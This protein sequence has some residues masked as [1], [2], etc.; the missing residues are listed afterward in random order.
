VSRSQDKTM[1]DGLTCRVRG[2][3][4]TCIHHVGGGPDEVLCEGSREEVVDWLKEN[5]FPYVSR[6]IIEENLV[7]WEEALTGTDLSA[8]GPAVKPAS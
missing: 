8:I 4:Y 7:T 1:C 2:S 5:Y 3:Q 6:H